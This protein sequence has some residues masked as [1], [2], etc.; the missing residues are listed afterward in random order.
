MSWSFRKEFYG[1]KERLRMDSIRAFLKVGYYFLPYT[2]F[3][4]YYRAVYRT[5]DHDGIYKKIKRPFPDALI[6]QKPSSKFALHLSGGIDSSLLAK[7]YDRKDAD[8]IHFKGPESERARALAVTLKGRFHEI[9]ITKEEFIKTADEII[10]LLSEPYP[11]HDIIFAYVASKKAKELGHNL[12]VAGDGGDGIFGGAHTGP[13]SRK[14]FVIWKTIDPDTLL[15]LETLQ[16]YMHTALYTWSKTTLTPH[17]TGRN[18]LFASAY[19]RELGMPEKITKQIKVPW[20][21]S[22]GIREDKNITS[23]MRHVIDS[24][25]YNWIREFKFYKEPNTGLLFRQYSL[26]KWL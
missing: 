13:Y 7:L 16:P 18:K 6:A 2:L 20:A 3:H 11:Y 17:E 12:I 22:L 19:C 5:G 23:H 9:E 8:Y 24:S 4:G 15:G 26:V 21:G 1:K 25:E 14:S 10:P